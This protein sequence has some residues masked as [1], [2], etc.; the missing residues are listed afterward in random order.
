MSKKQ[1]YKDLVERKI[2]LADE[3]KVIDEIV[4]STIASK[5]NSL[6]TVGHNVLNKKLGPNWKKL[7]PEFYGWD[8]EWLKFE[9]TIA[10]FDHTTIKLHSPKAIRPDKLFKIPASFIHLTDRE[11]AKMIR[12]RI[13]S[14]KAHLRRHRARLADREIEELQLEIKNADIKIRELLNLKKSSISA[15]NK[16]VNMN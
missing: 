16:F 1:D 15:L 11:F 2:A 9:T 10:D 8:L 7:G 3:N 5:V 12:K 13:Y 4:K 6:Y 14:H